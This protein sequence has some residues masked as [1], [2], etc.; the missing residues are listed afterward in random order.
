MIP[1]SE[2]S[3][4][5]HFTNKSACY[6][7]TATLLLSIYVSVITAAHIIAYLE[8][9][10]DE[11]DLAGSAPKIWKALRSHWFL[12]LYMP[13]IN[14]VGLIVFGR[15]AL[16]SFGV[17]PY[18]NSLMWEQL[19]RSNNARFAEKFAYFL[20]SM[21]Y[22]L[23]LES[24]CVIEEYMDTDQTIQKSESSKKKLLKKKSEKDDL[25][26][27]FQKAFERIPLIEMKNVY[28]LLT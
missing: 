12:F 8:V 17:Y 7:C 9:F 20:K 21:I 26:S 11:H 3:E 13:V 27:L 6:R 4:Q 5:R 24:G 22:T 2:I 16:F 19:E 18:Q 28:D 10:K 1:D 25:D 15:Y 23:R 14:L